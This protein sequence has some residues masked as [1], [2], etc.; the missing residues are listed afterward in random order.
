MNILIILAFGLECIK[1]AATYRSTYTYYYS[2]Y[3]P[4][5]YYGGYSF[6]FSYNYYHVY[7]PANYNEYVDMKLTGWQLF[8][9]VIILPIT[10]VILITA[11]VWYCIV[12]K[13]PEYDDNFQPVTW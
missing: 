2:Y 3:K 10:L 7:S 8:L 4:S 5:S 11:F 12:K 13:R 6:D 9:L 1:A